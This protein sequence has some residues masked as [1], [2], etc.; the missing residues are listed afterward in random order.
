MAKPEV[1]QEIAKLEEA[2]ELTPENVVL[3]AMDEDNPLHAEIEWDNEKAG[4]LYRL[5]Q[6]RTLIRNVRLE[7]RYE[8]I[9]IVLPAYV[10]DPARQAHEQGYTA[11]TRLQTQEEL[12]RKALAAEMERVKNHA[13]RARDIGLAL[14]LI[15]QVQDDL[16]NAVWAS[17]Q[18]EEHAA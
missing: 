13:D 10:R 3:T 8:T 16:L 11:V 18:A 17:P 4:P 2:G 5:D 15:A 14:G 9:K 12:K 1:E 6:A 7:V